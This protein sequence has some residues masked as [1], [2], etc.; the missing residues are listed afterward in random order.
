MRKKIRLTGVANDNRHS[1][2]TLTCDDFAIGIERDITDALSVQQISQKMPNPAEAADNHAGFPCPE[3]GRYEGAILPLLQKIG[4]VDGRRRK[5][6][7]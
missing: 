6:P 2:R 4:P 3:V 5:G 7:G 1:L